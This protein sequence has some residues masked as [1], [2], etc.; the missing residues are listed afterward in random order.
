[1]ADLAVAVEAAVG[2][3][4]DVLDS[5]RNDPRLPVSA[6]QFRVLTILARRPGLNLG[7]LAEALDVVPSS[8]SRLCDRL[9]ATGLLTRAPDRHDR[10]EVH[11]TLTSTA[12]NLLEDL[13][14]Q[15]VVAIETVLTKMPAGSR[16]AL[17]RSLTAFAL[18]SEGLMAE[19]AKAVEAIPQEPAPVTEDLPLQP[20]P[21][22]TPADGLPRHPGPAPTS[23]DGLGVA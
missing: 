6:T 15:R 5:A 12:V 11:L 9:A 23:A 1:M 14:Q 20:G 16:R 19:A 3:L 8:A 22:P 4:L 13:R 10:R 18:A 7:G 2:P 21:A 17:L